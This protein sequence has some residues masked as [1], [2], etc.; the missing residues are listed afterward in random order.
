MVSIAG[1]GMESEALMQEFANSEIEAEIIDILYNSATNYRY[2]S[3]EEFSFELN[4][5]NN[6]VQSSVDLSNSRMRFEKF[7]DAYCN[8]NYWNLTG[9]GGFSQRNDMKSSEAIRDIY[10]HSGKYGTE[11]ATA[12]I[13]VYFKALVDLLPEKLFLELFPHIYLYS[14]QHLDQDL[15]IHDDDNPTDFLPGDCRYFLNPDFHPDHGEYRGENAILLGSNMY[16]G[17]GIGIKSDKGIIRALNAK[18]KPGS[19]VSAYLLDT[20]NRPDYEY[21]SKK[22]MEASNRGLFRWILKHIR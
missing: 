16:Y 7:E 5:R 9:A 4:L 18:R 20:A 12:I 21:L 13:I 19:Q 10:I 22:Y 14:W 11:C 15:G 3:K 17:H 6:I 2:G 8:P 1:T